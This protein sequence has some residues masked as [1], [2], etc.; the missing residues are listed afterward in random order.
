MRTRIL[1]ALL[2]AYVAATAVHIGLVMAYEP[3]AFDAW[4]IAFDTN[5]EPI[6]AGRFLD[7]WWHQ[8]THSNPRI[9]QA[10]TYLAYKLEYFAVIAT[11]LAY[12]ALTLAVTVLALGRR[13]RGRDLALWAIAI[14]FG[15]FAFPEIG[16]NMFNRAYGANYVY[17]ATIQLWFLVPLRLSRE[18]ASTRACV[19]YA[20]AGVVA[21]MCNEHTGPALVAFL[22]G[23]AWWLRKRGGNAAGSAGRGGEAPGIDKPRLLWAGTIGFSIGFAAI[24]LAPGQSERYDGLVEKTSLPMRMIQRGVIGILDI[25]HDYTLYAAPL[26]LLLAALLAITFLREQKHEL[27]R[28]VQLLGI[29]AGIG[30]VVCVTLWFSPKLGSRFYLLPMALLLAATLAVIDAAITAPR[31][32]APFVV[33]AAFASVYA[34]ARTLPLY[35][36]VSEQSAERLA[37]LAA[38]PPGGVVVADAFDQSEESWWFIGDDFDVPQ[39]RERVAQYLGLARVSFRGFDLKAPLG[40][41]GVRVVG[42]YWV[43]GEQCALQDAE[44]DLDGVGLDVNG[45]VNAARTSFTLVRRLHAIERFEIVVENAGDLPRPRLLI[46]RAVGDELAQHA[47]KIIRP[48]ASITREVKLDPSM[49]GK[50][51]DIYIYQVGG[52]A[53]R[54]GTANGEP[55]RYTPWRTGIYWALACDAT[56]CW[57]VAAARSHAS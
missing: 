5:G 18:P 30:L 50:P 21:G 33:V 12:L 23:Y 56:E 53:R 42:R 48:G 8:Y 38:A 13:P 3:F 2:V 19:A 57:L 29:A 4:N 25:L 31:R 52:E 17:G 24:F 1:Y 54:L 44:L 43:R 40:T 51:F 41:A 26:L 7:Y 35:S 55:L 36:R 45:V 34:G 37:K 47:G 27:R 46:A 16:R 15:W 14:G 20:L 28:P 11:P 10:L 22:V 49:S 32:L 39:K 9:G 6:T